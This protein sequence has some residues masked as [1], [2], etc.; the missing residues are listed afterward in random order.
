MIGIIALVKF[1]IKRRVKRVSSKIKQKI[2]IIEMRSRIVKNDKKNT[3]NRISMT[4][5]YDNNQID[6]NDND[7]KNDNNNDN[8][9]KEK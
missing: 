8:D 5:N 3:R 4:Q 1:K 6:N 2:K 7:S 9:S